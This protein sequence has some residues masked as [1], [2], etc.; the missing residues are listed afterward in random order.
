MK[1]RNSLLA[2]LTGMLVVGQG[3]I[4][5]AF[6]QDVISIEEI[7]I[8]SRRYEESINDA[9]VAVNVLSQSFIE[10]N[11]IDRQDDIFNYT[12]GA[13]YESF[14]KLQPTA[15]IRGLTAPTPGNASSESSI[16]TV[17]DSVVITKDFMKGTPLFD[18]NRAEV[19]R[20]PQGTSFGR[21][22]STG[23]IHFVTNRP[24]LEETYGQVNGTVGNDERREVDGFLNLPLSDIAALRVS[25]NH[26]Q[27]D[28]QTQGFVIDDITGETRGVGGIDGEEN[29]SVRVQLGIEPSDNFSANF[30]IDYSQ[31]R[32]ESPIREFCNPGFGAGPTAG[33]NVFPIIAEGSGNEGTAMNACDTPFEAFISESNDPDFIADPD[34]PFA[35][36]GNPL[37]FELNRDILNLTA[38]LSWSLDNGL[39]ITSI[40]GYLDGDTDNLSD[41]NGTAADVTFQEVTNDG[42]ALSTELRIDNVGSDSRLQWLTGFYV[43]DDEET[44]TEVLA[45]QARDARGGAFVPTFRE[46]GGTNETFSWS[47]FAELSYDITDR[48]NVTY[49]GRFV[50][51]EKDYITRASGIGFSGQLTGLPGAPGGGIPPVCGALPGPPSVADDVC[52]LLVLEDFE[53][54]E[55]WNDYIN[56]LTFNYAFSDSI[57]GYAAYSEGFKSGAFQPDALNAAQASAITDPEET[58]NFELGLKG[59]GSAYRYAV[60]LFNIDLDDVQTVN[61]VPVGAAFVGLVSNI[62]EVETVGIEFDGAFALSRNLT[63]SAGFAFQDTE[64]GGNTPTPEGLVDLDTLTTI[65]VDDGTGTLVDAAAG[66][67]VF[68]DG[69]RPGGAPDWTFNVALD[70]NINLP[71]GSSLALR[72]DLRGRD[73]VYFQTRDRFVTVGAGAQT[74]LVIDENGVPTGAT[75]AVALATRDTALRPTITDVGA[76]VTWT[77]AQENFSVGI[78]GRNLREDV[79]IS[80]VGPFIPAGTFDN[81][82]GFRGKREFG[83]TASYGF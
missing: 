69:E 59:E 34:S 30:K 43:L 46:T 76:Q 6:A 80:N 65:Q 53:Q 38:E 16:Q 31:D 73:D 27:E 37:D 12:P 47:V 26:E 66:E 15:S 25:F 74:V 10:N 57:N 28:G 58:T 19:L 22:A 33:L 45:F 21:N 67:L 40:T 72:A 17:I 3:G 39:N 29:T 18:L 83:L 9:P 64:I 75:G 61:V 8:T 50:D 51:D 60:T 35:S 63:L 1:K 32:D 42:D 82:I 13:T 78:W 7:V 44:R 70:Y 5:P 41:V 14:S 56:K 79:D 68:L 62:G 52:P 48:L 49:G 36:I 4:A 54:T 24:D 81:A 11:R 20:G 23:L 77:N 55:S 71:D 2:A